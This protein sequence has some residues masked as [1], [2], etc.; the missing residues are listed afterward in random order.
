[1]GIFYLSRRRA[2]LN[3]KKKKFIITAPVTV[4]L[5]F[6]Y[7]PKQHYGH[8]NYRG[9]KKEKETAATRYSILQGEKHKQ[10]VR[11]VHLRCDRMA[12]ST[13]TKITLHCTM[14]NVS[15]TLV[16]PWLEVSQST[17]QGSC[18]ARAFLQMMGSVGAERRVH[19]L[20]Q[21]H[22]LVPVWRRPLRG[23]MDRG[24]CRPREVAAE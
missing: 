7:N 4:I 19:D 20:R 22:F 11:V 8:N 14:A 16:Q 6:L 3:R 21:S 5:P 23:R 17:G 2:L 15:P 9:T 1:M 12:D 24:E 10:Q 13:K 18:V